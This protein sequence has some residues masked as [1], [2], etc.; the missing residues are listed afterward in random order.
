[1]YIKVVEPVSNDPNKTVNKYGN[2]YEVGKTYCSKDDKIHFVKVEGAVRAYVD[3]YAHPGMRIE[4]VRFIEIEPLDEDFK[5]NNLEFGRSGSHKIKVIR[6]VPASQIIP[7]KKIIEIENFF[8]GYGTYKG[9]ET[10]RNV[11]QKMC[12][13]ERLRKL[14]VISFNRNKKKP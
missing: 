9:K 8:N 12:L 7:D 4:N 1:M 5:E 3:Y 2:T 10:P 13:S 6:I 14:L 11:E